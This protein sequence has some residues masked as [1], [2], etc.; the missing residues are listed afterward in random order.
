MGVVCRLLL[1]R[2][3]DLRVGIEDVLGLLLKSGNTATTSL[4]RI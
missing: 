2:S 1:L 3:K 4:L